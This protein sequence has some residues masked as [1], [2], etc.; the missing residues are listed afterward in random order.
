MKNLLFLLLFFQA[1]SI[2]AQNP[3]NYFTKKTISPKIKKY[4]DSGI[5]DLSM[6]EYKKALRNFKRALEEEPKFIDAQI[7]YA[8]TQQALGDLNAAE[9]G[10]HKVMMMDDQ[11]DPKAM[12]SLA[13]IY[14]K[15]ENYLDASKWAKKFLESRSK[16]EIMRKE[17]KLFYENCLFIS[18]ALKNP[19]TITP[20]N[21]GPNINTNMMEYIPSISIDDSTLVF[22]RKIPVDNE[23]FFQSKKINNEWQPATPI[24]ELNTL[25][26]EGAQTISADGKT[27]I[28]ASCVGN[29]RDNC[30]MDL[31]IS[32]F[33]NG[34]WTKAKNMG[35]PINT[36][37]W[38]SYPSLNSN[39][40][41]IYFAS[42]RVGGKGE[43]DLWSSDLK[44]DGSWSI[45]ENL[46]DSINTEG[47]EQAPFIHPDGNSLYFM[48]NGHPGMGGFDLYLSHKG[49]DGKWEKPINLGYPI[50]T[51]ANEGSLVVSLD[52]K[53]AYYTY[54]DTS[55][56]I[57]SI[58]KQNFNNIKTDIYSFEMPPK[59]RPKLVTFVKGIT[60]DN[61]T[62]QP[63]KS[64]VF[65]YELDNNVEISSSETD[66]N[67]SFTIVLPAGKSYG[68]RVNKQ[69]YLFYSDNFEVPYN[70]SS[71]EKPF[72][73]TIF[74][75]KI[76]ESKS[77]TVTKPI[78]LKNV[79]FK[80][81]SSTLLEASY[82][83]LAQLLVLLKEN[84]NIKIQ[85]NGHTD[86][87]GSE[88][89]NQVLS[90]NR[91]KAV[92][93]YLIQN[94]ADTNRISYKGFGMTKPLDTN[95]TEQGRQ[96]NRRTE[97]EILSN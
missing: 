23:D 20:K 3:S 5:D 88:S 28:Y 69:G 8:A 73:R 12:Y 58:N 41:R 70:A 22:T 14:W 24:S 47:V 65:I 33:E 16:N 50:N 9:I 81:G 76:P 21:L 89:A 15:M 31:F 54:T 82:I 43:V 48:S 46:G 36:P 67:G 53:T 91:A 96:N 62:K 7:Y 90:L 78:V 57:N 92:Y 74:L 75:R 51:R 38:E 52:G 59:L 2:Y 35:S 11:Y 60:L 72:T 66:E 1:F 4:F 25:N 87:I 63:I 40:K 68:F 93:D 39:G 95:D 45:P 55:V 29:G 85:I 42:K 34:H 44:N 19:V 64:T 13:Q 83:E 86:N 32:K 37:G 79:L 27:L 26:N 6:G 94:K 56:D 30:Q 71:V 17:V 61:E 77:I 80:T 84:P 18:E 10:F 97:F 49:I